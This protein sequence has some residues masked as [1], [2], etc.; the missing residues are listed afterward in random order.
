MTLDDCGCGFAYKELARI[1]ELLSQAAERI[2]R[3][4]AVEKEAVVAGEIELEVVPH[5]VGCGRRRR[6]AASG[7]PPSEGS[8]AP[9]I[10]FASRTF[11]PLP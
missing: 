5:R 7:S 2:A 11:L 10:F 9:G 3:I 4:E 1:E 8:A 6:G